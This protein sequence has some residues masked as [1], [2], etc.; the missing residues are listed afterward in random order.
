M[1]R[2]AGLPSDDDLHR[3]GNVVVSAWAPPACKSL[4]H[5]WLD[6]LLGQLMA[7]GAGVFVLG[8]GRKALEQLPPEAVPADVRRVIDSVLPEPTAAPLVSVPSSVAE[9]NFEVLRAGDLNVRQ[10]ILDA[11]TGMASIKSTHLGRFILLSDAVDLAS[12]LRERPVP[13]PLQIHLSCLKNPGAGL[14][15]PDAKWL[16][17]TKSWSQGQ[18]AVS[19]K[20]TSVCLSAGSPTLRSLRDSLLER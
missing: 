13:D 4:G 6:G 5:E 19:W 16:S 10:R 1:T 9:S 12:T 14:R 20:G 11:S 18:V 17:S 3:Y 15:Q 2:S 7:G 8:H